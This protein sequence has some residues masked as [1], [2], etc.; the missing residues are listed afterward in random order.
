M[1]PGS[2]KKILV[3]ASTFPRW[4]GDTEPP[5]I[6]K[7]CLHLA[8]YHDVDLLAPHAAGALTRE[9]WPAS[10]G[11]TGI[12]VFRF[13]YSAPALEQLA[14][15]GGI[16]SNLSRKRW[17][18]ALVPFFLAAQFWRLAALHRKHRYDVLH[19]HWIIPQGLTAAAMRSLLPRKQ[20]PGL[21]VT[22]HGGDLFAL[23]HGLLQRLKLFV[24][25]HA[26]SVTVVSQAMKEVCLG[27]G[28][29]EAVVSVRPMGVDLEHTFTPRGAA[30]KNDLIF[31]GRLVEKKGVDILL[32][33]LAKLRQEGL[34]PRL[35]IVG[36]G[37]LAPALQS[38][39]R[40]LDLESAVSFTG[41]VPNDALPEYYR[42]A[43]I[44]VMPSV[45]AGSG[46]QEGL[47]L[48]A[49]EAMGC[50]CA[51]I[52][53][54]LPA[55]RDVIRNGETG[56]LTRP[57]DSDDIAR[58]IGLLLRDAALRDRLAANGRAAACERFAW[59][60]VARGYAGLLDGLAPVTPRSRGES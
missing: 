58:K 39:A 26:D 48:V 4:Q 37:P 49:V 21:L 38:L 14:Y 11:S 56:L 15:T 8:R 13:R 44:A 34:A 20:R 46:D 27:L 9:D 30:R 50:G 29:D 23:K 1:V 2:R 12:R 42:D 57:G 35:R 51:A 32:R 31:V 19:A 16:L 53:S 47:G 33:A 5:F 24:L 25:R 55:I 3:L 40:Q 28:I 7:L 36:D 52:A 17:L 45:I 10:E 54:D 22:S 6:E 41:A 43:K 18:Y 60:D 59:D